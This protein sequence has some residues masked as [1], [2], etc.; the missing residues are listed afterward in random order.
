MKW[1][2][3]KSFLSI[4]NT[5]F[6]VRDSILLV[7][8]SNTWAMP[9]V[10][11]ISYS[12]LL[13]YINVSTSCLQLLRRSDEWEQLSKSMEGKT[14]EHSMTPALTLN[15]CNVIWICTAGHWCAC[16]GSARPKSKR[17]NHKNVSERLS[18]AATQ[19]KSQPLGKMLHKDYPLDDS[20]GYVV[21]FRVKIKRH[22][23]IA[24]Y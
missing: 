15:L 22:R 9:P 8:W 24:H 6:K 5:E 17:Q 1:W 19:W 4:G 18:C 11:K 7:T 23:D 3:T 16:W 2:Y 20:Q 21:R 14:L 12:H 13:L 10:C